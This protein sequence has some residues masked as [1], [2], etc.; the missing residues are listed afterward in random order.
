MSQ[1]NASFSPLWNRLSSHVN[2]LQGNSV[3][4]KD[5]PGTT[6]MRLPD[7]WVMFQDR[8]RCVCV[9]VCVWRGGRVHTQVPELIE[10][11]QIA[12]ASEEREWLDGERKS[13]RGW[14]EGR[15][16]TVERGERQPRPL[17][18]SPLAPVAPAAPTGPGIPRGPG[19]PGAPATP[20]RPWGRKAAR[21]MT[22]QWEAAPITHMESHSSVLRPYTHSSTLSTRKPVG[23]GVALW[24]K[25]REKD[26]VHRS[27][28]VL[29]RS[30][31]HSFHFLP[32]AR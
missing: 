9:C 4:W 11:I 18:T 12:N 30:C 19:R 15:E 25:G 26:T 27:I 24:G 20:G 29:L 13:R 22:R 28:S 6:E 8:R 1:G 7:L 17:T 16:G 21:S 32:P 14:T 3:D 5:A 23:P 10:R 2:D 31:L